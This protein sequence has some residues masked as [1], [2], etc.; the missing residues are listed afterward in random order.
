M[1][2]LQSNSKRMRTAGASVDLTKKRILA[3]AELVVS[4][5]GL[6]GATIREI[7]RQA[8]DGRDC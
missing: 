6:Q 5:D 8:G 4:S 2:S 3:A 1:A 7:A